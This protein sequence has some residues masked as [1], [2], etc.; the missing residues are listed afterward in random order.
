MYK[1]ELL[2]RPFSPEEAE[3]AAVVIAKNLK[4]INSKD[5]PA[6]VIDAMLSYYSKENII[7][8]AEKKEVYVAIADGAVRGTVSL[9]GNSI[10]A[11]FVDPEYHGTG[12]GKSL[13][14]Y[15]EGIARDRGFQTTTLDASLTAYPF[16]RRLGYTDIRNI[17]S[18]EFGKAI[19]MEKKLDHK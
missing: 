11:V 16:Y 1:K 2:I 14:E 3:A 15:I 19:V 13:M 9:E 10:H 17:E 4:E 5:Y 7:K 8:L 6:R 18:A 12:L